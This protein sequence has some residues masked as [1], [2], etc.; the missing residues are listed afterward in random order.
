MT[1]RDLF[2][3]RKQRDKALHRVH[4]HGGSFSSQVILWIKTN[5]KRGAEVTGEDIRVQA[6][7][8]GLIPHHPNAWGAAINQAVRTKLLKDTG[9]RMQM[10]DIS[11]H[12]RKTTLYVMR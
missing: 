2:E 1:Q 12:A 9:K 8:D 3:S 7:R 10:Q 5:V 6:T 4:S 11:S